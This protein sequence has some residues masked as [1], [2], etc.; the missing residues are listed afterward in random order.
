[1]CSVPPPAGFYDYIISFPTDNPALLWTALFIPLLVL[2]FAEVARFMQPKTRMLSLPV[3][4]FPEA[5]TKAQT[6]RWYL[7]QLAL[8]YLARQR[9]MRVP[10]MVSFLSA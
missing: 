10:D 3:F 9:E 8:L 6:R 7:S 2:F 4:R 5:S 1:M